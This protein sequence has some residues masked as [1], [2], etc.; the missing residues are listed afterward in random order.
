MQGMDQGLRLRPSTPSRSQFASPLLLRIHELRRW[1][2]S[3]PR[4][5]FLDSAL[6]LITR[7]LYQL[8]ASLRC[9]SVAL[10]APEVHTSPVCAWSVANLLRQIA[11]T[12][13]NLIAILAVAFPEVNEHE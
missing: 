7:C 13:K 12:A 11:S 5:D 1:L 10:D 3:L 4:L 8:Q 6:A 9:R 2:W